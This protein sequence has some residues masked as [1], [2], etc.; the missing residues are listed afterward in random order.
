MDFCIRQGFFLGKIG[1][2]GYMPAR[3]DIGFIHKSR[4]ERDKCNKVLIRANDP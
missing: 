2:P 1:D 3:N 4:K